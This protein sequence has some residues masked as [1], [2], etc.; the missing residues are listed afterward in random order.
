MAN[1]PDF[2]SLEGI[3]EMLSPADLVGTQQLS[4]GNE[5]TIGNSALKQLLRA[6]ENSGRGV[7]TASDLKT[8][9]ENLTI[10]SQD[11]SVDLSEFIQFFSTQGI[12]DLGALSTAAKTYQGANGD[13]KQVSSVQEIIGA[14][15]QIQGNPPPK[16]PM[17]TTIILSRSPFFHPSMRNTRK[18][19]LFLNSMPSTVLSQLVPYLQVEFQV[20]RDPSQLLQTPGL[21][22][23]LLGSVDK[24]GP[25]GS[26]G[27]NKAM[28]EAHQI[29]GSN[30]TPEIDYAGMELFTSPQTLVNPQPNLSVGTN[31]SRYAPVVDPFRPLASLE[32]CTVSS[33]PAVG[34]YCY[35]KAQLTLKVHDRS[36]LSELSDLIR[37]RVYTGVTVWLTYGWR[38]P[39]RPDQNPYFDYVNNNLLMREAYGIINS[40][41]VFDN[42]GQVTL[43]MELFTKGVN[44]MRQSKVSDNTNDMDF[45]FKQLQIL[46][47]QI[48]EYRAKL[49]LDKP[50]GIQ[51][52]IRTFQVLDAAEHGEFPN[53]SVQDVSKTITQLRQT[54][55]QTS[56]VDKD[57][58]NGLITTLQK[59]YQPAEN[60]KTKF[61]LQDRFDTRVTATVKAMFDE[62]ST[63]ADPFLPH[64]L[65]NQGSKPLVGQ[66]LAAVVGQYN[67]YPKTQIQGLPKKSCV[68]FGK[69][70][71]VF[72]LRNLISSGVADELQVFFYNLN[73]QCGPVSGHSAAEFPI[74]MLMFFDQY[75]Q[76][77]VKIGSE[78]ITLEDFLQLVVSAQFQD[79]RA[80]GY[81][82]R[83][84]YEAYDPKNPDA[85]LKDKEGSDN[86][87]L[88]KY[89]AKWGT[90]K[91]P[92]IEMYVEVSHQRVADV[93][94]SDILQ[95]M[96]YSAKDART[97][98]SSDL[99][100]L[101][102]R[103]IMR[104]HVYDKQM[105][106][107]KAAAQL[108][109]GEAGG[110]GF[111]SVPATQFAAQKS[112]DKT[113]QQSLP[114]NVAQ[115]VQ[116]AT[117]GN[118]QI[119]QF[120][121]NQQVKDFVSKAVPTIRYGAKGSTITS[122]QLGS[123]AEPLL[124]TVQM[125]RTMTVKNSAHANGGG[126]GGIPLRVIPASLQLTTLGNPLASMAQHFF[127]DFGTGTSLDNLYIVT[128]L[129][130]QFSP[131]KFE[132]NWVFGYSDA[133]GTFEGA[134]NI[135][136]WLSQ[137]PTDVSKPK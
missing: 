5:P 73:D 46:G 67:A 26:S 77:V 102:S 61:S 80:I 33:V 45:Q 4:L 137:F 120:T 1:S 118:L 15:F 20:T 49:K 27:A 24:S 98:T 16:L 125:I 106:P 41:F 91:K 107:H 54:L 136:K 11:G 72:A 129:T 95:L 88:G 108:L 2:T 121:S 113:L 7:L 59:L 89:L 37:P 64:P 55:S 135:Q 30:N 3:F 114:A 117:T 22:K 84:F 97:I 126:D 43:T 103:K 8:Q 78:R 66:E 10:K 134:P 130:H 115:V 47:K 32:H 111:I 60:N 36:R 58:V 99:Q 132:T 48:E 34:T 105:N 100:S 39:V 53:F 124:S 62:V 65:K 116:D 112:G 70:F 75:R 18:V 119:T 110:G 52:E 122:A 79:N 94:K 40:N 51:K 63:G 92:V 101:S 57:A 35:K 76:H 90:F 68:S 23:F 82:M 29:A 21:V 96:N 86:S 9:L 12:V 17:D 28:I 38:A 74:D 93:G 19:E 6:L 109:R 42:A 128:G 71:T 44:E 131:G 123:K 31:G 56:G 85:Q 25:D 81:G 14:D 69:L 83:A 133:Y 104:I 127:I 87:Q 50:E 13:A